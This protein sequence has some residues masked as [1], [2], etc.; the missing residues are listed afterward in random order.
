[1]DRILLVNPQPITEDDG[2]Q[3]A[4]NALSFSLLFSGVRCILQYAVLPFLLPIVG[5]ATDA[6]VPILLVIN[7]LAMVS[8]VF[9]LR[10]FW[11]IRYAHRWW[12]L[13]VATVALMLLTVFLWLDINALDALG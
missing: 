2:A 5:I 12:Y 10:R 3:T 4:Q 9:S 6:A 7:I 11:R 13:V 1:M 8:I